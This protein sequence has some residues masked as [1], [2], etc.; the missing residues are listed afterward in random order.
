MPVWL[1]ESDVRALLP[2]PDL[3]EATARAVIAFS[4]GQVTQPVRTVF[5]IPGGFFATMPA[6]IAAGE[7]ALGAK[8]VTVCHHN[9][10]HGLPS[11]LATILLMDPATGALLAVMDGRYI[12]EARTAA[13]SAVAV[14]LLARED[15]CTLAIL[16]SGVQAR[17]HLQ[18]LTLVRHFTDIRVWSP[19][20][21]NREK[22]AA[23]SAGR[24]VRAAATAEEAARNADVIVLATASETP[25]V[26][27]AWVKPGAC[28]ASV[29]ACRPNQR[30]MDPDLVARAC[31]YVDSRAAA[32]TESGDIFQG[33]REGRFG[34]SHILAE[35][36]E[37]ASNPALGRT[38]PDQVT[39]F[40]SVGIAV[41][42]VAAAALV[43]S[44]AIASGKGQP[45]G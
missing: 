11:H 3:I 41:E 17:S 10:G 43:H 31:L 8:L 36:G 16:G 23:E 39:I 34:E 19:T 9:A 35:L 12:T 37:L 25:A 18:A 6:C 32:L 22:F 5:A 14:R 29:G 13:A 20:A 1:N 2:M 28:I 44:R 40:K 26:E 38:S 33:I 45:L 21:G 7:T 4:G 30:E 42:D 27:N 24:P 15:A